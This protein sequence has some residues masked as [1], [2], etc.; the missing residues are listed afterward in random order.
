MKTHHFLRWAT[1]FLCWLGLTHTFTA[2]EA[3]TFE[4]AFP[5]LSFEF[6]TEIVTAED[7]SN[8]FFVLEQPGRIKVFQNNRNTTQQTTFLDIRNI[9]SFSPG[10]EIGLLGI[11]FHPDYTNNGFFYVYHTRQSQVPGVNVELVLARYEVSA[12]NPNQ[13]DPSSRLDIFSFDK[14]QRQSN[15]NGGKIAFGPDGYLYASLGDGGGAGDPQ[16]NAQNLNTIFGSLL[17]IDV[18][19]DGNNPLETNPDLPNGR[20]E[21]P[22]DN[23]LVGRSG[24]DELF[25]WGIR[26][27]W[28]FSWDVPTGR[29]WGADVGQNRIEEIN[30]IEKGG[31]YGWNRF[32][33]NSTF[34]AATNL[35]TTPDVKPIFTY[36]RNNGDRSITGG[37]VYRGASQ[38]PSIQGKYIYG[39]YVSGRVWALDYN[40]TTGRATSQ[41]LFRTN[42]QFVSSFG[43]DEAGELYFIGYGRNAQVYRIVGGN[44]EGPDVTEIEGIGSWSALEEGT[45]GNVEAMVSRGDT[46]YVAGEFDNAGGTEANG[47]AVYTPGQGWSALSA[48]ANGSVDALA[49]D[50][51]GNLYA[52][53]AFTEIGGVDAEHIAV[54]NG[55]R[56]SALEEGTDGP[57]IRIAIDSDDNVYAGGSFVTAGSITVNNLARWNNG[58]SALVDSVTGEAGTN[59]EI[60]AITIDGSVVYVGGNFASAGG[61][62]ANRIAVFNGTQWGTLGEGTSGFVQAI[63]VTDDYIYAGGNFAIAGEE[64][65]NRIA[66]WD[67]SSLAWEKIENGVSG[68]VNALA[69]DGTFLYVG[70]NFETATTAEDAIFQVNN[71]VRWNE[72]Q[73]W[74]ALG[75]GTSVGTDNRVRSL[76][77]SDGGSLYAGGTFARA[78]RT[79]VSNIA[80]WNFGQVLREYWTNVPGGTIAN[81]TSS[82]NYPNSPTGSDFLSQ[83]EAVN[84]NNPGQNSNWAN[85]YGQRIRGYIT[86]P[87]TGDYTFWLAGNNNSELYLGTSDSPESG[88]RIAF[89]ESWTNLREW[90]KFTSQKSAVV[91]LERGQRYYL[92]VLQKENRGGDNLSVGWS[93]PGEPTLTPS[94]I[95]PGSVLTPFEP[96]GRESVLLDNLVFELEPQHNTELRLDVRG[97]STQNSVLV[98]GYPG[99]GRS[100]QQWKFIS[101]GEGIYEI[102]PQHAP[103][104]RLDV[105]GSN[106][107]QNTEIHTYDRHGRANQQW[108]L[109]PSDTPEVYALEPVNAPGMR[110]DIVENQNRFRALLGESDPNRKSQLWRLVPANG[111]KKPEFKGV[112]VVAYPNPFTTQMILK[113]DDRFSFEEVYVTDITGKVINSETIQSENGSEIQLQTEN[114]SPGVYFVHYTQ[115]GGQ[116]QTLKVIKQ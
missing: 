46:V 44:E 69:Y 30:L 23:P 58:W 68:N 54:W 110:L 96:T 86:A 79:A 66:R 72:N 45:D 27:T 106:S 21:I 67:R 87:E 37:F 60:R 91:S 17:R 109:L 51:A 73:G 74:Q 19:L 114:W 61:K 1:L 98:D 102:E 111:N 59:N 43:L 116:Q 85:S 15:H 39:D 31:N 100:N 82:A 62:T 88:R 18:D 35:V 108:R 64:T 32:E 113:A 41:L 25:V 107:I 104:K 9:V 12:S 92:E 94:E 50:S 52:G 57:V 22:S 4:P 76:L 5:N 65:V 16:R 95:I 78:G 81:L 14:N 29:M 8:R 24:L 10:E 48:G 36:N 101:V 80:V 3:V 75:T 71:M 70:G 13:A 112:N 42:G 55:T 53:G 7:G 2:Q 11:A 84:W 83:L 63:V 26:N 115:E 33:G 49:L 77:L 97:A 28:K 56:W 34:R 89:V 40:E 47:I 20:Y 6:P 93:K 103:G 99:H 38:N 105:S 90:D